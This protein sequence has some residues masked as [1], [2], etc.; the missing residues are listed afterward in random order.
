MP[1]LVAT[2]EDVDWIVRV[3]EQ[4]REPLVEF[5]PVFWQ[6]ASDATAR[7]AA[8]IEHLLGEGDARAYRTDVSVLVAVPREEGWL[9]D[10]AFVPGSD[11]AGG[12]GRVLWNALDRDAHGAPVR[13]VC[14]SYEQPRAEF[15]R[16]AGLNLSESWW[17]R[18]LSG[19]AGG[20]AGVQVQLPGAEAITVAAPPVYDPPGPILFLPAPDEPRIALSAAVDEAPRLGAPAIV[21]NQVAADEGLAEALSEA[22][23]RRHCDYYTGTIKPI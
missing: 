16:R 9:V 13:F 3:L 22:G 4:R 2:A 1:A 23:F 6:P 18:E 10:D 19:P 21:V 12:D 11:W 17:L 14:P 7:H 5:A 8:F 15:A 20:E